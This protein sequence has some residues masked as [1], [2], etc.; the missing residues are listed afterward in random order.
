MS[1]R[2]TERGLKTW[3]RSF[4]E[5]KEMASLPHFSLPRSIDAVS[6]CLVSTLKVTE[7]TKN[8]DIEESIDESLR[9]SWHTCLCYGSQAS[10][11]DRTAGCFPP[12][13]LG[14]SNGRNTLTITHSSLVGPTQQRKLMPGTRNLAYHSGLVMS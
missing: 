2:Q 3:A 7:Q 5:L 9:V 13:K 4:V 11:L 8:S 10:K 12:V 1:K 6:S 14:Y